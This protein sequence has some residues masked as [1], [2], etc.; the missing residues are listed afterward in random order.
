MESREST[1][2]LNSALAM[3][4]ASCHFAPMGLLI[5]LADHKDASVRASVGSNPTA[6]EDVLRKLSRDPNWSVRS[7]VGENPSTPAD[8]IEHLANDAHMVVLMLVLSNPRLLPDVRHK[9]EKKLR[10]DEFFRH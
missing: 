8:A 1:K 4:T 10:L 5:A 6:P 3:F 2:N 9:I 7:C